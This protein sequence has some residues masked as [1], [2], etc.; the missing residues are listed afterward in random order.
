MDNENST[1]PVCLITGGSSG[2]GLA[3]ARQFARNGYDISICGRREAKLADAKQEILSAGD[4]IQC[5]TLHADLTDVEQA[6]NVADE[7]IASFGRVDVLVN[8][9]SDAPWL[10]LKIFLQKCLNRR[11]MSAFAVCFTLRRLCGSK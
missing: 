3:T 11:S 5:L 6:R 2:I 10:R 8:N 7:T 9:A 4:G 1:S